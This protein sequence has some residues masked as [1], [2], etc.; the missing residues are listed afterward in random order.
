MIAAFF[1]P[2]WAKLLS[3]ALLAALLAVGAQT[4]RASYWKGV[5]GILRLDLDKIKLASELAGV[6]AKAKRDQDQHDFDAST[7]RN[8]REHAQELADARSATAAFIAR[9]RLRAKAIGRAS[10]GTNQAGQDQG[11]AIP[12]DTSEGAVLVA[13]EQRD[14]ENA[15]DTYIYAKKA[16]DL[17]Q[18]LIAKD[19]AEPGTD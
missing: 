2:L 8:R 1:R 18:D 12:A 14:V 7:E 19:L 4:Y 9:S 10:S 3:G 15:A 17:F 13:V 11:A 5:A 6:Q 16:Y